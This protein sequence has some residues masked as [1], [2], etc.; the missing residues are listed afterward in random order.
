[1]LDHDR[2][3]TALVSSDWSECLSPSGPFDP[4]VFAYPDLE[5]L[6]TGIFKD[7]TSNRISLGEAW[8]RIRGALP[9]P[10]TQDQM[11]AYL[12]AGFA[13]YQGVADLVGWCLERGI[14]FM[15][16]TTA[17]Q[18]YFQRAGRN[19]LL[20]SGM[21][22]AANPLI[23]YRDEEYATQPMYEVLEIQDK[24]TNTARVMKEYGIPPARVILVG[25]SGGDGPHFEWGKSVGAFLVGSMTKPSLETYC[26]TRGIRIDVR[27]GLCYPRGAARDPDREM[28]VDFMMLAPVIDRALRGSD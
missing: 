24:A 5:P 17:T 18:G 13:M 15:V 25:D 7:Y 28:Q 4:I 8:R 20:P 2:R 19:S 16:N 22:V 26:E 6:L 12:E 9:S 23:C 14:L 10:L 1:M 11:D 21:L 27:F 3:F